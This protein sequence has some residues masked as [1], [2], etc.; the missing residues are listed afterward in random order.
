MTPASSPLKKGGSPNKKVRPKDLNNAFGQDSEDS[1]EDEKHNSK[2]VKPLLLVILCTT[3][4]LS[5]N[6]SFTEVS[7]TEHDH[8]NHHHH[9]LN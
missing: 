9:D 2:K 1:E 5:I 8:Y 7:A 6:C 4:T 3:D